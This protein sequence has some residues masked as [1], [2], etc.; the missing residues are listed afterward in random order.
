MTLADVR[1]ADSATA[2][3]SDAMRGAE[4]ALKRFHVLDDVISGLLSRH[5]RFENE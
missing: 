3:F 2:R 5:I 4:R 1:A